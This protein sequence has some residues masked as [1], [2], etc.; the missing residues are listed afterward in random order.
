VNQTKPSSLSVAGIPGEKP[1][2]ISILVFQQL[3]SSLTYPIAKYGLAYIEPFT[4]AFFR[5]IISGV[6]LLSVALLKSKNPPIEKKDYKQIFFL[7]VLVILLNQTLFLY[8]QKLTGAGHGALLFATTPIWIFI[9]G[10]FFLK[11]KFALK[12]AI[13]IS[14]GLTGVSIIMASGAIRFGKE[15]L[16][17]DFLILL[18]VFAWAA[19]TLA[20]RPLVIKYG[21]FRVTAYAL[22]TGTALYFPFGIYRASTFDYSHVPFSAWLSV[23]FVAFG[24]S[25]GSYVLWNWV[26]KYMEA[27]KV[28]VFQNL[29]P[30]FATLVAFIFLHEPFGIAFIIG[31]IIVLTGVLITRT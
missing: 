9:G 28:A 12:R 21:A 6:V 26:L 13:G 19:Y 31:G 8:G 15:Y 11:E 22:S 17:G 5:Y 3:L 30:V 29:Q 14:L 18:S 24:I 20:S 7:A 1:Y 27:T 23:L 16:F 4:F 2:V 10:L 25:I